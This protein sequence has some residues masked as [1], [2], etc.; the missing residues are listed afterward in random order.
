MACASPQPGKD[1]DEASSDMIDAMSEEARLENEE[2]LLQFQD[3]AHFLTCGVDSARNCDQFV[4]VSILCGS[5]GSLLKAHRVILSACSPYFHSVLSNPNLPKWQ[6]PVLLLKDIPEQD[7]RDILTFVYLGKVRVT[8]SRFQSFLKSAQTLKIRGLTLNKPN[9]VD[10]TPPQ[11][12]APK[13]KRNSIVTTTITPAMT[14]NVKDKAETVAAAAGGGGGDKRCG[15]Q[16]R[17]SRRPRR[18]RCQC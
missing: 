5:S 16:G 17:T 12:P 3:Y 11:P 1:V 9:H 10:E 7:L 2:Y 14:N 15:H 6:H 13:R 4:D 18:R 8:Q